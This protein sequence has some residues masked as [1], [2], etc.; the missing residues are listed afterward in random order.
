MNNKLIEKAIKTYNEK[1]ISDQIN[2]KTKVLDFARQY[3]GEEFLSELTICEN[4]QLRIN[5]STWVLNF[6]LQDCFYMF[7]IDNPREFSTDQINSLESLGKVYS[8]MSKKYDK[9]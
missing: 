5:D 7:N 4:G 8:F 1:I 3:F 9:V 6:G 2:F